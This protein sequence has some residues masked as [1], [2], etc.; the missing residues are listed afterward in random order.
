M[1][2]LFVLA[3]G[4]RAEAQIVIPDFGTRGEVPSEVVRSFM[5]DFRRQVARVSGLA[6]SEG[7]L[8][9]PGIAGS[10]DAGLLTALLA[11]LG[12]G[13]Y[14]VSG[15]LSGPTVQLDGREQY[16]V[17]LLIV[18][19][20]A[21]RSSDLLSRVFAADRSAE[22]TR[23]LAEAVRA[24]VEPPLAALP[25]GSASL[26]I[27]SQPSE[28]D[29]FINGLYVG[30]TGAAMEPLPVKPGRYDIEWR[31]EGFLPYN[32]FVVVA[33]DVIEFPR[34]LLTPIAA[35][36]IQVTSRPSAGVYLNDRFIGYTP[37]SEPASPGQQSLRLERPGFEPETYGV[38][39][40]HS[41][42]SRV[43]AELRPVGSPL[44]FW[45]VPPGHLVY[46]DGAVRALPFVAGLPGGEHAVELVAPEETVRFSVYLPASG[47]Y[48]LDFVNR[49]LLPLP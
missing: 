45:E 10:L 14:G 37:L 42:V 34:A 26:F 6:V 41:R 29:V 2:L 16:S 5:R 48:E 9:S 24:F 49:R 43:Q 23:L 12:E 22:T 47:A 30:Q 13:R 4:Q 20:Q 39:V 28:A 25:E 21:E 18:D 46:I 44:L 36:S 19:V 7:D 38:T 3:L 40:Q 35:G 15:E 11:D 1:V 33:D 31:K 8:V 17:N 32:D 27:S